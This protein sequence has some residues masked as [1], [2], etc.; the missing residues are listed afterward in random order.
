MRSAPGNR[1]AVTAGYAVARADRSRGDGG[2]TGQ[3]IGDGLS[4]GVGRG[5]LIGLFLFG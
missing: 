5:V 1:S 2:S 3:R 4:V